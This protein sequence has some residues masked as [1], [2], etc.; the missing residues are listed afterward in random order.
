M[1]PA[2]HVATPRRTVLRA[3]RPATA[4]WLGL[5]YCL[6]LLLVLG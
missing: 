1:H 6:F 3:P 2:M 4:A 5:T